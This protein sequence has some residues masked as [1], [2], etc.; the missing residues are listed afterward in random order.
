MINLETLQKGKKKEPP[1]FVLYGNH[2]E[3]K[4]T[5]ASQAPSPIFITTEDGLA[6]IDTTS[7]PIATSYQDVLDAIGVLYTQ[8]H[9]Y[10]TVVLDSLD[11]AENLIWKHLAAEAGND[12]IEDFGYGKGYAYAADTFRELLAGLDALRV[13]KEMG[14]VLIAH[15]QI[16]R[17]DSPL[18]DPY[19]RYQIKL[20][21][22]A[23]GV[24]QEW[25]DII[26]FVTQEMVVRKT[27][28]GFDKK[29]ARGVGIGRRV[30]HLQPTP[31]YDAKN[32]F[33]LPPTL[34]LTWSAF[35]DAFAE[36][37]QEGSNPNTEGNNDNG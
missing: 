35:A 4:S 28:V 5:L 13:H 29:A 27:D 24:V 1:R 3:G 6:G 7:F 25:A 16:K 21:A 14:V 34:P 33:N 22:K 20:H 37:V 8:D 26:A 11:W 31:A 12:S 32:R 23:A 17:F 36:A 18:S 9:D 2:G 30:M 10:K 19:D 15:A